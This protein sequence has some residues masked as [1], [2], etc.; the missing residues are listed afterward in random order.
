MVDSGIIVMLVQSARKMMPPRKI[1]FRTEEHILMPGV[2]QRGIN[3]LY[4]RHT[5]RTGRQTHISIRIIRRIHIFVLFQNTLK[6]EI[7]QSKFQS[8]TRFQTPSF[9]KP[10]DVNAC[11]DRIF[12]GNIGLFFH[13]GGNGKHIMG[14]KPFCPFR[15][16][17]R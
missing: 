16:F 7:P 4:G 5:D 15:C 9:S 17:L 6:G 12:L 11:D 10:I 14:R 8:G 3:D 13:N 1:A 2:I